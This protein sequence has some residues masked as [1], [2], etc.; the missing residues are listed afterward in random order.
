MFGP[1]MVALRIRSV[2]ARAGA[3][4]CAL[5]LVA[6][7]V[8]APCGVLRAQQPMPCDSR[9]PGSLPV[10]AWVPAE[11]SSPGSSPAAI[12]LLP[13]IA[14]S[15]SQ[16]APQSPPQASA[17]NGE[18][19]NQTTEGEKK[20]DSD[21]GAN[22]APQCWNFHAQ[23][24]TVAQG[25]PGFPARYSGP[26]SLNSE[27]ER[28]ETLNAD[29]FIGAQLWCGAELHADALMWEGFGLS[30]TFGIEAFPNA[31]AYKAGTVTP[32]FSFAHLFVRQTIGFGGEQENIAD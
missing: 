27:G 7:V 23:T 6:A 15:T 18:Q 19:N 24:T 17:G 22:A 1:R 16:L 32:D 14:P 25:D 13:P 12:S 2:G 21:A 30:Q 3:F 10:A 29:L 31:D 9:V 28:Q 5:S 26:N 11:Q 8:I 20:S 4:G